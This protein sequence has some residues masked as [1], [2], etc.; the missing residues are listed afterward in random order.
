MRL[1]SERTEVGQHWEELSAYTVASI[2]VEEEL[3]DMRYVLTMMERQRT[4]Q[5]RNARIL[6]EGL[7]A[8]FSIRVDAV[9]ELADLGFWPEDQ[10]QRL[11]AI[12]ARLPA[13]SS[14]GSLGNPQESALDADP[15]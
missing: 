7:I 14:E 11:T 10:R 4:Q 3:S 13:P 1:N 9:L 6:Q 15:L 8:Q 5:V 2:D 12:L